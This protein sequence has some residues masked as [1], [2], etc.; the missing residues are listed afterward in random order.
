MDQIG[1]RELRQNASKYLERVKRGESIEV[2][3][4]GTPVARLN[5]IV[6]DGL[7]A[8]IAD[9]RVTP[10]TLDWDDLPPPL[11]A[12]PGLSASEMLQRQRADRF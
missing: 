12:V 8:M 5:P 3:V 4:H 10:A 7:Q 1:V 2:T 11:P 6:E 9:G